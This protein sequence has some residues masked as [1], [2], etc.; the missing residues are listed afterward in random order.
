MRAEASLL[1]APSYLKRVAIQISAKERRPPALGHGV[2]HA[3]AVQAALERLQV[4]DG[5]GD[6][7]VPPPVLRTAVHRVRVWQLHQM[8]L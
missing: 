1:L 6:V 3:G 2:S 5:E 7:S 8:D 4:C